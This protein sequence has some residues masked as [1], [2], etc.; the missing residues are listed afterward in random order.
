MIAAAAEGGNVNG[1]VGVV[2]DAI[3]FVVPVID[4]IGATVILVGA[5]L[6]FGVFVLAQ[7]RVRPATFE[8]MRLL[9]GRHL[10]LGLEFQLA[11]DILST[12][13]SPSFDELGKLGAIAAIRTILNVFLQRELNQESG[14]SEPQTGA[15]MVPEPGRRE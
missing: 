8:A 10:A 14:R 2:R 13:V 15:G 1:L 3:D 4:A 7:I 6:A 11:S 9:L 12:A 5:V